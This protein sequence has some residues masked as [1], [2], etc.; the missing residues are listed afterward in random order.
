MTSRK[1][2]RRAR[3]RTLGQLAQAEA[4]LEKGEPA[5]ALKLVRRAT[6]AGFMNPRVWADAALLLHD[7]G[8]ADEAAAA[9][10]HARELAPEA[11]FVRVVA[12]ELGLVE[13]AIAPAPE[14]TSAEVAAPGPRTSRAADF[15]L[16]SA[17][18]ELLRDGV[19]RASAWLSRQEC[20]QLTELSLDASEF[21]AAH[22][23]ASSAGE[24]LYAACRPMALPWLDSAVAEAYACGAELA[25]ALRAELALA[26]RFPLVAPPPPAHVERAVRLRMRDASY[27]ERRQPGDR[28]TFPLHGLLALGPEPITLVLA[29]VRPGKRRER[30]LALAPGTAAWFCNRERPREVGGVLGL[31]PCAYALRAN[32]AAATL[33]LSW[34]DVVVA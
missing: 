12:V 11:D 29:D 32:D 27:P 19:A 24:L 28:A 25:N 8:R 22:A 15:A 2:I 21:H 13:L 7:L 31:Q 3:R 4:A 10:R 30:A 1:K 34:A 33:L 5:L 20:A 26:G 14:P 6:E 23:L 17:H 18:Q 16:A 9:A